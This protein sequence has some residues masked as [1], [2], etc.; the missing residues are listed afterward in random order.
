MPL[1]KSNRPKDNGAEGQV[2]LNLMNRNPPASS[3]GNGDLVENDNQAACSIFLK[4]H[5]C[6]CLL[7]FIPCTAGVSIGYG[8]FTVYFPKTTL[9]PT[10]DSSAELTKPSV[11]YGDNITSN[12]S[13]FKSD[14]SG[15]NAEEKYY[16]PYIPSSTYNYRPEYDAGMGN[17]ISCGA[18]DKND[19]TNNGITKRN[20]HYAVAS[21]VGG[22]PSHITNH[23]WQ[24][25]LWTKGTHTCGG[26]II[27][28]VW[29]LF[30][31]HCVEAYPFA[32]N[33]TVYAGLSSRYDMRRSSSTL[34]RKVVQLITHNDYHI[35]L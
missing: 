21:I 27:T 12:T 19:H 29:V 28:S 34:K 3:V 24:V 30:A 33:W 17:A 11:S 2:H 13:T 4:S 9:Q 1:S 22:K 10:E 31:A 5:I 6:L 23:P 14:S 18:I 20:A 35:N 26:S 15:D 32:N 7:I 8:I 25:S 16:N